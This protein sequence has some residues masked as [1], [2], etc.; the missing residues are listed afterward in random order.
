MTFKEQ[1]LVSGLLIEITDLMQERRVATDELHK[2]RLELLNEKYK[3]LRTQE[4]LLDLKRT[5]FGR[6]MYP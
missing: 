1:K 3:L 5:F 4:E 6:D 2:T